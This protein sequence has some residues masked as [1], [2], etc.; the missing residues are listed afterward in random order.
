MG[1]DELAYA[2]QGLARVEPCNVYSVPLADQGLSHLACELLGFGDIAIC[3]NDGARNGVHD[4]RPVR[5]G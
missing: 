1:R 2:R 3:C 4:P 5:A